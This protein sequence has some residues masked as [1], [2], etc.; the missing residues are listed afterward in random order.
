LLAVPVLGWAAVQDL[1]VRRVTNRLWPPLLLL[2][3]LLVA[4][5]LLAI[6][7]GGPRFSRYALRLALSVGL[8]GGLSL[9]FWVAGGFGGADAK[10]FFTLSV[11][12]PTYPAYDLLGLTLPLVATDV[13]VFS[14]TVLTNA[15]LLGASYPLALAA[16]N[17]R[18]GTVSP[19]AVVARR[20]PVASLLDRHGTL[21][22]TD[23]GFTRSGLDLDALRM[24]LRWRRLDLRTLRE[25][26]ELADPATLPAEP[27]DPTDGAVSAADDG[28]GSDPPA[29]RDPDAVEADDRWG[30]AAFLAAIDSSAYGTSPAA[31]RAGLDRVTHEESVWVSPGIPFI[32]PTVL[33]LLVALTAGDLLFWLL[34]HLGLVAL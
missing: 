30:A 17:V 4:W 12:Y 33:G 14:L 26:P 7:V 3:G 23:G 25:R 6:G 9:F 31:L 28:I 2:G 1:R 10:A 34:G 21:L 11:L 8:V 22:D 20:V 24:Y 18:S 16:L 27:G 13:G 19:L 29:T 32:V 5:D 15:V